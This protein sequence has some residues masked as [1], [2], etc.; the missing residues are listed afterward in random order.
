MEM[1]LNEYEIIV[2]TAP[3]LIWRSG[4]DAKCYYFFKT[5]L[6]FTGRTF[7][8]EYGNGWA[9]GVHPDDFDRCLKI[10]LENFSKKDP[11]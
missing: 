1:N 5:W 8:Q 2:E 9:E 6:D 11:H 3:N 7:K 10:Y 4:L